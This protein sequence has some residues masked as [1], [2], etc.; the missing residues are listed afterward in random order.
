[1][2]GPDT[3]VKPV[4]VEPREE[5]ADPDDLFDLLRA[6]RMALARGMRVPPYVVCADKTLEDMVRVMPR[7][8][9]EM[10]EVHGMGAAKVGKYGAAFL[11]VVRA[12]A[13]ANPNKRR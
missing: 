12:Y 1:M 5:A 10:L 11:R 6:C 7:S 3:P 2:I 13:S 9:D 4:L 8:L